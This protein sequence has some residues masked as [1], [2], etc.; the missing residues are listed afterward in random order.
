MT[1]TPAPASSSDATDSWT[2]SSAPLTL[3]L[4]W[5]DTDIYV[6][7][8]PSVERHLLGY[9]QRLGQLRT[10]VANPLPIGLYFIYHETCA[11]LR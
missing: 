7:T 8:A 1:V 5:A 3:R 2:L 6:P 9:G 4:A 10:S 11:P